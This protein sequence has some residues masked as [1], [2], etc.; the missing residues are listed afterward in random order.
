MARSIPVVLRARARADI[1]E[2]VDSY[3][4]RADEATA[5]R[6]VDALE[7]ALREIGQHPSIGSPRYAIALDLPGLRSWPLSG[8]P[9]IVFYVERADHADVWRVLHGHRD[10]PRS[11]H[12]EDPSW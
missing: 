9:H 3:R 8:F 11:L 2:T 12:D 10:I 7:A 1:F 6:F 4:D 5:V